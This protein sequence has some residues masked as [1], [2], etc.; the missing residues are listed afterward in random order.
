MSSSAEGGG[1]QRHPQSRSY[2]ATTRQSTGGVLGP[3]EEMTGHLSLHS[4]CSLLADLKLFW[5]SMSHLVQLGRPQA[6]HVPQ[7]AYKGWL[8]SEGDAV[9]EH[10]QLDKSRDATPASSYA[11][12]R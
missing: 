4:Q 5:G 2:C 8:D 7:L 3:Y 1:S 6:I 12:L 9:P 10:W 11:K